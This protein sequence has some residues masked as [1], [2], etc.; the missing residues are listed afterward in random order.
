[1]R[2]IFT[3]PFILIA[4]A[5][6]TLCSADFARA[7]TSPYQWSVWVGQ[8]PNRVYDGQTFFSYLRAKRKQDR[9][10]GGV[11]SSYYDT[12]CIWEKVGRFDLNRKEGWWT[13][14][15]TWVYVRGKCPVRRD[16]MFLRWDVIAHRTSAFKLGANVNN[17][18]YL[19]CMEREDK[20][21]EHPKWFLNG[22]YFRSG[23]NWPVTSRPPTC[24]T[25]AALRDMAKRIPPPAP[26]PSTR[27]PYTCDDQC[28]GQYSG[29][30][31]AADLFDM[32]MRS[33]E[34]RP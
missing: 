24:A 3:V 25:T 21:A 17:P 34:G 1:M 27:Q 13:V 10:P 19:G 31:H 14:A 7:N 12:T 22:D 4:L 9:A 8:D 26:A 15:E 16:T 18:V 29:N 32:C 23:P 20:P 11:P 5:C 30:P 6:S 33:C 28:R 2:R